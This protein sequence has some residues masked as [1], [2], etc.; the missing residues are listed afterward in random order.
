MD[1]WVPLVVALSGLPAVGIAA[2][3][4]RAPQPGRGGLALRMALVSLVI[5]AGA[6]GLYWAGGQQAR[7]QGVAAAMLVAVNVLGI[8]MLLHARRHAAARREHP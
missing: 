6:L 3:L 7:V 2:W 4:A 5:F 1:A 8:S